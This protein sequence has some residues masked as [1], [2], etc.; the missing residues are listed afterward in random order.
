MALATKD[1]HWRKKKKKHPH[2]FLLSLVGVFKDHLRDLC[3]WIVPVR[4][5]K[6]KVED[7]L[8][9]SFGFLGFGFSFGF[10]SEKGKDL[11]GTCFFGVFLGGFRNA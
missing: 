11:D 6:N 5:L 4:L 10:S 8:L 9:S 3:G 1:F 7:R 2:S